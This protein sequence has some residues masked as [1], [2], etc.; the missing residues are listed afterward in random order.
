MARRGG[1]QRNLI[2][3]F[4]VAAL[5]PASL[6]IYGVVSYPVA[7]RTNEVGIRI[8][9]GARAP[10]SSGWFIPALRATISNPVA[11]LRNE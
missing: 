5:L 6:G 2:P 7:T 3:F 10:T 1:G 4:A 11:R 8:A 9:A